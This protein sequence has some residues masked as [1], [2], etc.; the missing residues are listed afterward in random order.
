M[1]AAIGIGGIR[2]AI[3]DV[4]AQLADHRVGPPSCVDWSSPCAAADDFA[5]VL[6]SVSAK[7][8]PV[9]LSMSCSVS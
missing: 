9:T 6:T 4:L 5:H 7:R 8:V 1:I 3:E 2:T